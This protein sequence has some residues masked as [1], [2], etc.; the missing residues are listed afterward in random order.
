LLEGPA[1]THLQLL[2][3]NASLSPPPN[4]FGGHDAPENGPPE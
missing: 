1:S 4:S 2:G 3:S